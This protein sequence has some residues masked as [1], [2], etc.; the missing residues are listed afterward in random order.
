MHFVSTDEAHVR[1]IGALCVNS[2]WFILE[3]LRSEEDL[4]AATEKVVHHNPAP[5][6][7]LVLVIC[8]A[9]VYESHGTR[10]ALSLSS[11][12]VASKDAT[13]KLSCVGVSCECFHLVIQIAKEITITKLSVVSRGRKASGVQTKHAFA[14]RL[15]TQQ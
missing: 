9:D 8:E 15:L 5:Q 10:R 2:K 12:F 1:A 4:A 11:G 13:H 3:L 6:R 14:H 7:W